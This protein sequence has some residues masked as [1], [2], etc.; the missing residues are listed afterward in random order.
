MRFD[1]TLCTRTAQPMSPASG[2][3]V[4]CLGSSD[5]EECLP[6]CWVTSSMTNKSPWSNLREGALSDARHEQDRM[7][8]ADTSNDTV[9]SRRRLHLRTQRSVRNRGLGLWLNCSALFQRTNKNKRAWRGPGSVTRMPLDPVH[10]NM[11][12]IASQRVTPG[13]TR[14][15][16][17]PRLSG[18]KHLLPARGFHGATAVPR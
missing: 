11:D 15:H 3:V 10:T 7:S 18:A 13:I 14:Q 17:H 1:R 4:L 16:P 5:A 2:H 8:D 12:S 6:S 9:L